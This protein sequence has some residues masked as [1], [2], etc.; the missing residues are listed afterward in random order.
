MKWGII[1]NCNYSSRDDEAGKAIMR[2]VKMSGLS[3]C[4]SEVIDSLDALEDVLSDYADDDSLEAVQACR[5]AEQAVVDATPTREQLAMLAVIYEHGDKFAGNN[6]IDA[7]NA[8]IDAG[9][10]ASDADGWMD[11]GWWDAARAGTARDLGLTPQQTEERAEAL[12][13]ACDNPIE[14]YT[15]GDVIY[16]ICNCDTDI[17]VLLD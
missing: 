11:A 2:A 1:N 6:P 9:F 10:S 15:D 12:A 14:E 13:D 7:A 8:W 4:P 3:H 5:D 16:S 17:D